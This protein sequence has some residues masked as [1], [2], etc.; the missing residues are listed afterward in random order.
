MAFPFLEVVVG[1]MILMY[2]LETYMNLRQHSALKRPT[3]PK[4]LEGVISQ[5]KYEKSRAY[6]LEKS[7]FRFVCQ[8]VN[9][10]MD[11]VILF[12]KVFPWFWKKSGQF[13]A[14]IGLDEENEILHT[15]AFLAG[16]LLWLELT[17]LP[18]SLY[19]IFVIEARHGFNKR[20]IW[21]FF[22][23]KFKGIC[24]TVILATP[25]VSAAILIVK[26]GGAYSIIYLWVL[27][28]VLS[29]VMMTI[30]PILI[31]PIFHKFTP[32]PDGQLREKIETL[33]S[34]LKFPLKKLFVVDGSTRSSHSNAY[35][36]G[37]FN[38][39]RIVLYDTL[40]QQC[41]NDEEIV[42]VI[43]H[44]LGHWKHNH[45]V[46]FLIANQICALLYIGGYT[47]VRNWSSL[48]QSFG[49]HTRPLIIALIIF[50]YALTPIQN[51]VYFAG[52]LVSRAFEYQ[53]DAFAKKLGYASSIRASLVRLQEENLS[54]MNI[55]PWYSAYHNTH[56]TLVERLAAIGKTDKEESSA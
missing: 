48:F 21:L 43:A 50:Q 18:F 51:L 40:I 52:N 56:P 2:V 24:L 27:I 29:L 33:A 49:F 35:M 47:L 34:S 38:N 53:A 1:S 13:V 36:Y 46:Y 26:K 31:A 28:F 14:L 16:V 23:D 10:L 54:A 9:I 37:F 32:L 4:S 5:E 25:F 11:S 55:D 45:I 20:T 12:F 42:A 3:L 44:E 6:R 8:L 15:L 17:N 41:E 7:Q 30:Y 39:K 22:S 19:S